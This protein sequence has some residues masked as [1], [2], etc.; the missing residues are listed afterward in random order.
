MKCPE[1]DPGAYGCISPLVYG[2]CPNTSTRQCENG[3]L[4]FWTPAERAG[5]KAM[6]RDLI[7]TIAIDRKRAKEGKWGQYDDELGIQIET[8]QDI[9][10]AYVQAARKGK[11]E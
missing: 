2:R 10:H 4:S 8:S 3:W 9:I 6:G 5:L 1:Y 11:E 7:K